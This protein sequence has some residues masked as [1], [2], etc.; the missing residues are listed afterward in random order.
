MAVT[1]ADGYHSQR[2]IEVRDHGFFTA[3][4]FYLPSLDFRGGP[5]MTTHQRI[6]SARAFGAALKGARLE[7][8]LSQEDLAERGDFDRTYPSML[9]KGR[10][11]PTFFVILQ[12]AHAL[13]MEPVVLFVE[14][15]ARLR[16]E[17]RS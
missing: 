6:Q 14:A 3:V 17:G 4:S 15:V 8:G 13:R 9:E 10:R 11:S 1:T 2:T 16:K 12:L 7:R 5:P